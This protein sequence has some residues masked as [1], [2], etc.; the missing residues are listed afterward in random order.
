MADNGEYESLLQEW[1]DFVEERSLPYYRGDHRLMMRQLLRRYPPGK[2]PDLS[3]E[4]LRRGV[5]LD[6]SACAPRLRRSFRYFLAHFGQFLE[7]KGLSR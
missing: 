2:L 5:N 4:D 7:R 1:D 3:D 6:D